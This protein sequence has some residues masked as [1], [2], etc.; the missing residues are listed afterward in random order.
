MPILAT[1]ESNT[2]LVCIFIF[3][4]ISIISS[5]FT[6]ISTLTAAYVNSGKTEY[7]SKWNAVGIINLIVTCMFLDIVGIAAVH[8][9]CTLSRPDTHLRR[10]IL[11]TRLVSDFYIID[12][13]L[14]GIMAG[15]ITTWIITFI[16]GNGLM[17][18]PMYYVYGYII[19]LGISYI[20]LLITR[21]TQR[22]LYILNRRTEMVQY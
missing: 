18:L 10:T 17:V 20:V 2:A 12:R 22:W 1:R 9:T 19:Y 13:I 3:G 16:I 11:N 15:A 5:Y 4:I 14:T 7:I 8:I 6:Y 21:N